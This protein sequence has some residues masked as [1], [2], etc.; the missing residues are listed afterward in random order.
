VTRCQDAGLFA[1]PVVTNLQWTKGQA[2]RRSKAPA[3]QGTEEE[4]D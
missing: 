2:A 1:S 4:N 3:A